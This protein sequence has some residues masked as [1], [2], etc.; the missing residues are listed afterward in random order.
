MCGV[1]LGQLESSGGHSEMGVG[2]E[3]GW[4]FCVSMNW[5]EA[6]SRG[7]PICLQLFG[8]SFWN[9][10]KGIVQLHGKEVRARCVSR[11]SFLGAKETVAFC[12]LLHHHLYQ[13]ELELLGGTAWFG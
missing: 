12:I 10:A 2:L 9:K 5:R 7:L 13:N 11:S 8:R 4:E 3:W 1:P 6:L